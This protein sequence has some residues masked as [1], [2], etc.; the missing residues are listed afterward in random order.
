MSERIMKTIS[1]LM[2]LDRRVAIITGAAGRLGSQICETL[3]ELGADVV[4][5]DMNEHGCNELA[6]RIEA[7]YNADVH[8]LITNLGS[9][10]D[11][12]GIP[13][14]VLSQYDSIDILV[15]CA[16]LVGTSHLQ[17]WTTP[18]SEQSA[19]TWRLALEIN[20]TVPFVLTQACSEALKA[21]EHGSVINISSIYGIVGPDMRLYDQTA[22]GNPAAYAASKGGLLQLTRWLATILAPHVRVNAISPGG[23]WNNQPDPFHSKYVSR[24]PLGRMATEEDIKGAVAYLASDLSA[25]VTGQNLIIDGGFTI[26]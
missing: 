5:V 6:E 7:R 23:V 2:Q 22:M 1:T 25:Y 19:D 4:L 12:R 15:N 11:V 18:F 17:G 9:E 21:T 20:L 10:D 14:R 8:K 24:T 16:A 26:W 13:E 3:A